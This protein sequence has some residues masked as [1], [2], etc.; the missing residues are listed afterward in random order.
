[1]SGVV[2]TGTD[3]QFDQSEQLLWSIFRRLEMVA[4]EKYKAFVPSLD[5][6]AK[7]NYVERL[8]S[9]VDS[10]AALNESH[11]AGA[12]E[13]LVTASNTNDEGSVAIANGI[14]LELLGRT[15]YQLLAK[16]SAVDSTTHELANAGLKASQTV[17]QSAEERLAA[18]FSDVDLLFDRFAEV[19]QPILVQLDGL[20]EEIDETFGARFGL[21]FTEMLSEFA[22]ELL[23]ICIGLGM[24][25]RQVT[26]HL[27]SAF[28]GQ[29]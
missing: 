20:S 23:P 25:R 28:M 13:D 17:S 26:C 1:M 4:V 10:D 29:D 11:L 2:D 15:I 9:H 8:S 18:L 27:A 19:T 3:T 21:E 24:N 7:Q 6:S 22:G 5:L 16:N 12:I 14:V